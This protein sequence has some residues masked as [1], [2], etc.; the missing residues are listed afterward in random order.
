MPSNTLMS[1]TM[2]SC[3][4]EGQVR[5]RRFTP[6]S[7]QFSYRLYLLYLDL[8]ELPELF[9]R[10]WLWSARQPN[11]A[12]FRRKDHL[13]GPTVSLDTTIRQT[14]QNA[15]GIQP[16]GPIRLLTQLRYFGYGF[17]PVSFYYCYD[18]EDTQLQ[19]IVAE[20]NNTPWGEQHYY[21]LPASDH[22]G[23]GRHQRYKR[24]KEFHVSPFMPMDI[25]YDW[26]FSIPAKRLNVHMENYHAGTK[27]VDAT[28]QLQRA[29][30]TSGN[31]ARLLLQYPFITG[32]VIGTIYWQA[33]KLL[34]KKVPFYSHPD[35]KEAP[36]SA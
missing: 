9:D 5:H 16:E 17:N 2:H 34:L 19:T 3:I 1:I 32:K 7:H 10:Y 29:P 15:T 23:H 28:L 14:I 33:L 13:G 22:S 18:R 25:N 8:A 27:V 6:R 35:K 24:Q 21:V 20:V 36:E 4:Y 30:I 26:R 31:L 11:L 12:W